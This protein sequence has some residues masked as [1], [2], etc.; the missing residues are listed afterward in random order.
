MIVFVF[1][2]SLI[3]IFNAVQTSVMSN[4]LFWHFPSFNYLQFKLLPETLGFYKHNDPYMPTGPSRI[5]RYLMFLYL[6]YNQ[7]SKL[8]EGVDRN[9][10]NQV[11][12]DVPETKKHTILNHSQVVSCLSTCLY[13]VYLIFP[14]T[15]IDKVYDV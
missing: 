10:C 12:P 9:R 13:V 4:R 8:W 14:Y 2:Y 5:P 7:V 6:Q 11:A 15:L 3:D 1:S